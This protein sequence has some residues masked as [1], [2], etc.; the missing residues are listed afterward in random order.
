MGQKINPNSFRLGIIKNW[1]SSWYAE[2]G[3]AE[4][5]EQ[6]FKVRKYIYEK[7]KIAGISNVVLERLAKML[8]VTIHTA[9]PGVVIGKKGNEIEKLKGE[10][11]KLVGLSVVLNLVE[12]RKPDLDS[13][14]VAENV[15]GQI[16]KR[17]GFRRA[18]RRA[19]QAALRMGA[20]GIRI[21]CAGR[22]GGAEIARM[23]WYRDGRVPLHTIRADVDF[24]T[25]VAHTTYGTIGIKVW[26]YKGEIFDAKSVFLPKKGSDRVVNA[27]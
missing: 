19:M 21:N 7:L 9:K 22:L 6:D 25:A 1:N 20:Q 12:V 24:G 18:I 17:I 4:L 14:L 11:S 13:K 15:A 2:K 10:L 26:I 5:L 3:Y 16:E 27:S 23:E 8:V